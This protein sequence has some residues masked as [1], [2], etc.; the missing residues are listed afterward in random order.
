MAWVHGNS[1]VGKHMCGQTIIEAMY[2]INEREDAGNGATVSNP[3]LPGEG[4]GTNW[5]K[6]LNPAYGG[7][8]TIG[9]YPAL[10][11]YDDLPDRGGTKHAQTIIDMRS[12]IEGLVGSY[13]NPDTG[14]TYN[15]TYNDPDNLYYVAI[16]KELETLGADPVTVYDWHHTQ[17]KMRNNPYYVIDIE[18]ILKCIEKLNNVKLVLVSNILDFCVETNAYAVGC[19]IHPEWVL[20]NGSRWIWRTYFAASG[21]EIT[22]TTKGFD[23]GPAPTILSCNGVWATDD[24]FDCW[25]NGVLVIAT[26]VGAVA[27]N[28]TVLHYE[29]IPISVLQS[30]VNELKFQTHN[31]PTLGGSGGGTTNPAGLLYRV[32]IKYYNSFIYPGV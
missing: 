16:G 25:I 10:D 4:S 1:P 23:L 11:A 28:H 5:Q 20:M 6:R 2:A 14:N 21:T 26:P 27:S 13:F 22:T 29:T 9:T 17:T 12:A 32:E 24:Y 15:W 31:D 7:D 30:G 3:P 8:V 18:E 19:W